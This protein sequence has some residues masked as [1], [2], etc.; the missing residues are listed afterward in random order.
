MR[1]MQRATNR[2]LTLTDLWEETSMASSDSG[3]T[4]SSGGDDGGESSGYDS[5]TDGDAM[6]DISTGELKAIKKITRQVRAG[7]L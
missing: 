7:I 4:D 6:S 3:F 5:A 2:D 1:R